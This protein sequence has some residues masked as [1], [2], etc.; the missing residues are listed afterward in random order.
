MVSKDTSLELSVVLSCTHLQNKFRVHYN[1]SVRIVRK[2]SVAKRV[3]CTIFA[4][5]RKISLQAGFSKLSGALQMC[6]Y[7]C[8]A[9][10][11]RIATVFQCPF[12]PGSMLLPLKSQSCFSIQRAGTKC[13]PAFRYIDKV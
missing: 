4:I 8:V 10:A 12:S 6:S 1:L 5:S 3:K 7:L 2:P 9:V 11:A 13:F